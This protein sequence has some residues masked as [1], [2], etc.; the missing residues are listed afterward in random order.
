MV[1]WADRDATA[2]G[3]GFLHF[4]FSFHAAPCE[5]AANLPDAADV[6]LGH[7]SISTWILVGVHF[8]GCELRQGMQTRL[9]RSVFQGQAFSCAEVAVPVVTAESMCGL[10]GY[11]H[12]TTTP[13]PT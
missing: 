5:R 6:A 2:R 4:T 13:R 9:V 3:D 7:S 8:A 12:D 11:S 1:W 10:V